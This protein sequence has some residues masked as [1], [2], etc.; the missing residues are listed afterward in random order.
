MRAPGLSRSVCVACD[1]YLAGLDLL[2]RSSTQE[3]GPG[4][5]M[6][7][8]VG[9]NSVPFGMHAPC[10]AHGLHLWGAEPPTVA[11]ALCEHV[12]EHAGQCATKKN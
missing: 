11:E 10:D 1:W 5:N 4:V 9:N 12:C 3:G 6:K 8:G 2:E 7:G